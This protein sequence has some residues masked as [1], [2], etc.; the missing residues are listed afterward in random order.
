MDYY[1]IPFNYYDVH[2]LVDEIQQCKDIAQFVIDEV[3]PRVTLSATLILVGHVL[4]VTPSAPLGH[5]LK[6]IGIGFLCEACNSHAEKKQQEKKKNGPIDIRK[7]LSQKHP[8]DIRQLP[9][10]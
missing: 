3:P 1:R 7:P 8:A 4:T 5:T 2:E 9:M 6:G 10:R